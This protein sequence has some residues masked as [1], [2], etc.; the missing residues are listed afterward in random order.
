M[1]LVIFHFLFISITPSFL[2]K[3]E[4]KNTALMP[5]PPKPSHKR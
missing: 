4:Q 2:I 1:P 5:P 3:N